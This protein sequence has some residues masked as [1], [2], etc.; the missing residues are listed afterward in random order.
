M[1]PAAPGSPGR[2]RDLI[3]GQPPGEAHGPDIEV[4]GNGTVTQQRVYQL[5]RQRGPITGRTFEITL[6]DPGVQACCFTFG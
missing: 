4:D 2:C 1:G 3:D 5:I 6:P